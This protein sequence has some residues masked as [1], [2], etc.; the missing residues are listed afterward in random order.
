M[1]S[2][3]SLGVSP[4]CPGF[5]R[6]WKERERLLLSSLLHRTGRASKRTAASQQSHQ[7]QGSLLS[8]AG[9][10]LPAQLLGSPSHRGYP[11]GASKHSG[12]REQVFPP[13]ENWSRKQAFLTGCPAQLPGYSRAGGRKGNGKTH[14]AKK[15]KKSDSVEIA[16]CFKVWVSKRCCSPG[17]NWSLSSA[18]CWQSPLEAS[19]ESSSCLFRGAEGGRRGW[20]WLE[21]REVIPKRPSRQDTMT[22]HQREA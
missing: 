2:P 11:L 21:P 8:R 16:Q 14:I 20:L 6:R 13:Q 18:K 12:I 15:K 22:H 19:P 4:V 1:E 10:H 3:W 17:W 5:W 9:E 7:A